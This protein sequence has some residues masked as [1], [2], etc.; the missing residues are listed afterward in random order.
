MT[1]HIL[2]VETGLFPPKMSPTE[3]HNNV[4]YVLILKLY[5]VFS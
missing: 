5:Y 2:K 3:E 4:V 1:H